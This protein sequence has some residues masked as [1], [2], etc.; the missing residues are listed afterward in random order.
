MVEKGEASFIWFDFQ[1]LENETFKNLPTLYKINKTYFSGS[2]PG[3]LCVEQ[4]VFMLPQPVF[5]NYLSYFFQKTNYY[6]V[7]HALVIV[8][9]DVSM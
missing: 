4:K 2:Y 5:Q 9:D 3:I 7:W 8:A 6:S 1:N